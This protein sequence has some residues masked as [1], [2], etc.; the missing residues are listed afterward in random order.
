MYQTTSVLL[1]PTLSRHAC[2]Y[3]A[4]RQQVD[5]QQRPYFLSSLLRKMHTGPHNIKTMA[6]I[7]FITS[8]STN[9]GKSNAQ[10]NA[11]TTNIIIAKQSI[12][13][14]HSQSEHKN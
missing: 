11:T 7:K 5:M 10:N 4:R 9:I 2:K 12:S 6:K 13:F 14:P 1:H 8:K 3:I